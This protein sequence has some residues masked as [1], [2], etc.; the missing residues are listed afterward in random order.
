MTTRTRARLA[1]IGFRI[2]MACSR[3]GSARR[4][5]ALACVSAL[6]AAA[7]PAGVSAIPPH[8][9]RRLSRRPA[10]LRAHLRAGRFVDA[11]SPHADA[12]SPHADAASPHVDAAPPSAPPAPLPAE[13]WVVQPLD[14]FDRLETRTWNQRYFANDAHWKTRRASG[15]DETP[16]DETS[17]DASLVFLCVGGEG[18]AFDPTVVTAGGP[19]CALAVEMAASRGALILALEHRFYGPS[20]PTGDL[21]VASLR[22]LSSAQALADAARFVSHAAREFRVPRDARWVA[23]GGSYPGMLASWLRLKY[24]H[25]VHAAVASSAPVQAAFAMPGY[26]RVV[27]ESLAETDVGGSLACARAVRAAF[28][29]LSDELRTREGRR[30]VEARFHVCD[31]SFEASEGSTGGPLDDATNRLEFLAALSEAFPAQSND[32]AC[33]APACDISRVCD[34]MTGEG[35]G[36]GTETNARPSSESDRDDSGTP[37]RDDSGTPH[38]PSKNALGDSPSPPASNASL[39]LARLTTV[40]RAAFEGSCVDADHAAGV[41]AL[42]AT[43]VSASFP[44]YDRSWFWQTCAEFGF[45]QTCEDATCPFLA[46]GFEMDADFFAE[47]CR[48][49][50]GGMDP[51]TVVR[52]SAAMSNERYGGWAPGTT[53][54][55]YPSGSVDPWR[56]NSLTEDREFSHEWAPTMT[57]RGAS[58]HAWTHPSAPTDQPSVVAARV[59]IARVVD[60]WTAQGPIDEK[61][62][63]VE[64]K[65]DEAVSGAVDEAVDE[66]VSGAVSVAD[67]AVSGAVSVADEA[68]S[69]AVSVADDDSVAATIR[70]KPKPSRGRIAN[71]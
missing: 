3:R 71:V 69:G 6:V 2:R 47:T 56:A 38:T 33:D 55:L 49:V 59:A 7:L 21:T 5:A 70:A 41:A 53:R 44:D 35:T 60:R 15:G 34:I 11:A 16:S 22:H 28:R 23:F 30:R 43:S 36:E 24:P 25:L 1:D 10:S 40:V 61:R 20:Q 51:A 67:E 14:H 68:V 64:D 62:R 27:G 32:P 31:A 39:H 65:T 8:P 19:H 45:Y 37:D 63:D 29:A 17:S 52:P 42:N 18:P 50:F 48:A 26:D 58:H 13:R 57:V 9:H 66:G 46:P 54:V 4:A 12:A